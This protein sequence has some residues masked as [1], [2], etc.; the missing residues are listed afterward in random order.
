M[1][2]LALK[3]ETDMRAKL[4]GSGQHGSRTMFSLEEN[5][6]RPLGL[7]GGCAECGVWILLRLPCPEH[8]FRNLLPELRPLGESAAEGGHEGAI[9]LADFGTGCHLCWLR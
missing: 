2:A 1:T 5:R 4:V 3:I 8:I 9:A 7:S 6:P